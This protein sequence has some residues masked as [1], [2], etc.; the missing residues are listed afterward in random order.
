MATDTQPT[1]HTQ[2]E[3]CKNC[4]K[5]TQHTVNIEIRTESKTGVNAEYSR[6]PYRVTECTECETEDAERMNHAHLKR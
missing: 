1:V 4:M 6:E 5:Y 2:R 3:R